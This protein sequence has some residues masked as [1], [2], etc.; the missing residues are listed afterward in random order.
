[1]SINIILHY[2]YMLNDYRYKEKKCLSVEDLW[3]LGSSKEIA[4]LICTDCIEQWTQIMKH[5][6]LFIQAVFSQMH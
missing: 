5:T 6:G 2:R 4:S 1:M 3:K